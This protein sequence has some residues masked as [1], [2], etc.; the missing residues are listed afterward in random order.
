MT[1]ESIS[2]SESPIIFTPVEVQAALMGAHIHKRVR[3][4]ERH[5]IGEKLWVQEV[6]AKSIHSL[7][8]DPD[9]AEYVQD[10][11]AYKATMTYRCGKPVNRGMIF[12]QP[13]KTMPREFSRLTVE[14]GS[15]EWKVKS[16]YYVIRCE[17][18]P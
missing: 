14:V 18:R 17:V 8:H 1:N 7:G 10:C 11:P 6:W 2:E 4:G 9:G 5:R 3:Y 12:W 16:D 15:I 13:A